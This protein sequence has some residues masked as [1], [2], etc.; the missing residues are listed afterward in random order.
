VDHFSIDFDET[1]FNYNVG[2]VELVLSGNKEIEIA[3]EIINYFF[4]KFELQ[5]ED[6]IAS[7]LQIFLHQENRELHDRLV[8]LDIFVGL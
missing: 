5:G 2:E 1:N 8:N 4:K 6:K 7:K 3:E